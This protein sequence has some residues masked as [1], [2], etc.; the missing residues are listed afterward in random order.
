M[1]PGNPLY[2]PEVLT[3]IAAV[4]TTALS[5]AL[6]QL[7]RYIGKKTKA[8]W[9][10]SITMALRRAALTA[11]RA[12]TQTYTEAIKRASAD[13]KLTSVEKR[14]AM[15]LALAKV[16]AMVSW[17][18]LIKLFGSVGEAET[19]VKSELESAVKAVKE[20]PFAE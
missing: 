7:A 3:G 2:N 8:A 5:W 17:A 9:A 15:S 13:G 6:L 19:A 1:E 20:D 4:L 12:V 18:E 16:K 11:V 10:E 14:H